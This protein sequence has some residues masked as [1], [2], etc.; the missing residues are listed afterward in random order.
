MREKNES[1]LSQTF[2]VVLL[3]FIIDVISVDILAVMWALWTSCP[4]E[5]IFFPFPYLPSYINL[6]NMC[7][8]YYI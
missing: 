2:P 6:K 4:R 8:L 7:I 3:S 5:V 1:D